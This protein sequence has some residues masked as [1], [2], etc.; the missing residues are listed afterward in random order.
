MA[1][2]PTYSRRITVTD[3]YIY[4]YRH[5]W[6]TG[7]WCG[8]PPRRWIVERTFARLGRYWRLSKD[9]EEQTRNSETM[10][11]LDAAPLAAPLA[12]PVPYRHPSGAVIWVRLSE[13]NVGPGFHALA[14]P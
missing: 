7:I 1:R 6:L 5:A 14:G 13:Q 9:Y 10:I 2:Q 11:R 8:G 12:E 3:K 4:G